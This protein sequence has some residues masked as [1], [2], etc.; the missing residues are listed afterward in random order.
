MWEPN[1]K[2]FSLGIKEAFEGM[3]GIEV[4]W[5]KQRHELWYQ[6][7]MAQEMQPGVGGAAGARH[8]RDSSR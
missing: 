2:L 6:E 7:L 3:G 4:R 1:G 5:I 8:G